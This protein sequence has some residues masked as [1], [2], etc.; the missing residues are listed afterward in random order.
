MKITKQTF[1]KGIITVLISQILVKFLGFIYRVVITNVP[2]F[3]D[4]GNAYYGTAYKVYALL[5]AIATTGIPNAIS[6]LV[7]EKIA[8]RR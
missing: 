1:M 7:S 8:L 5:L 3:G 6:K 2:G 4:E